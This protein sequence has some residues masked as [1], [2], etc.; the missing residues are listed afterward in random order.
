MIRRLTIVCGVLTLAVAFGL[1]L[2]N[3]TLFG[4]RTARHQGVQVTT[5]PDRPAS[6][7]PV[8]PAPHQTAPA[9][10]AGAPASSP[11]G[12]AAATTPVQTLVQI[13]NTL[14]NLPKIIHD[15]TQGTSR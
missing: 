13:A 14:F 7:P 3:H 12:G 8:Q 10:H 6:W 15:R 4:A 2:Q 5:I 9:R 11:R 1:A